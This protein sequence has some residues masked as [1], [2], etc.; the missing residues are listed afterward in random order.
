MET[1]NCINTRRSI[2]KFSS[3]AVEFDKLCL[4]LDAASKAPTSGN[5]QDFRFIV[6]TDKDKLRKIA[7]HCTEQYWIAQAPLL[8]VV[9]SDSERTESYYGL[10]GQRLYSIQNASAA[11]QNILL[12]VHAMGLGA[13]WV[14]SFDESFLSG[15]LSIPDKIRPQALIPIGYSAEEPETKEKCELNTMVFF[16]T[17]GSKIKNLNALLH[18]YNKEIER[19]IKKADPIVDNAVEKFRHKAKHFINKTKESLKKKKSQ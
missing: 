12:S 4:I 16:N 11:I 19:Y 3:K 1:L 2:R 8:I 7:D 15:E 9:C 13:C 14:G 5:L 17:Y 18:E 10:R 6:V